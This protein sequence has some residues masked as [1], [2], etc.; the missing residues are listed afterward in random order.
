LKANQQA[1]EQERQ[2]AAEKQYNDA[3]EIR[4]KEE[5]A[6]TAKKVEAA[7]AKAVAAAAKAAAAKPPKLAKAP[8]GVPSI[9]SWKQRDDGT[10]TLSRIQSVEL[11]H[12]QDF[13]FF[14]LFLTCCVLCI[15]ISPQGGVSGTIFGSLNADDGDYIET[16]SIAEGIIENGYVVQTASGSRYFLS[17]DKAAN[18]NNVF[19]TLKSMANARP[20]GTITISKDKLIKEKKTDKRV[21]EALEILDKGSPRSTFSL[22]DLGLGFRETDLV[23]FFGGGNKAPEG[24]PKLSKWSTNEDGTITGIITGSPSMDDGE[25]ITTSPIAS[26]EKKRGITITTQ[27]GSK[28]FLG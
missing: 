23:S 28:Y 6:D 19:D 12:R 14:I 2:A 27:S 25:Y 9:M 5:E 10:Y 15:I 8:N 22:L 16:S 13:A 3:R 26:G 18:T 11:A 1:R 24:V 21:E 4:R 20:R 7:A 17:S